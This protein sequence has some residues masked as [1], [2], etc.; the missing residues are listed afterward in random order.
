[1]RLVGDKRRVIHEDVNT[2][3]P[4]SKSKRCG[5]GRYEIVQVAANKGDAG[6]DLVQPLL[7][8]YGVWTVPCKDGRSFICKLSDKRLAQRPERPGDDHF[9]VRERCQ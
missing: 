7:R 5:L 2:V 3:Q 6:C 9:F 1:V 8:V 4:I